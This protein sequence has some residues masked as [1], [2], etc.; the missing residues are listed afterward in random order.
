MLDLA[1]ISRVH[2]EALRAVASS[3]SDSFEY[4]I[5]SIMEQLGT[6]IEFR[7][8]SLERQRAVLTLKLDSPEALNFHQLEEALSAVMPVLIELLDGSLRNVNLLRVEILKL[9]EPLQ[10]DCDRNH[11]AILALDLAFDIT[12]SLG[13]RARTHHAAWNK[14]HERIHDQLQN[15]MAFT[16]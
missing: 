4:S 2:S 11:A 5:Q 6:D 1:E 15:R 10:T 8:D 9:S 3:A 12:G 16:Q 7:L 13:G 14:L